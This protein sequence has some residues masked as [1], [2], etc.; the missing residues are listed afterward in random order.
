MRHLGLRA[1]PKDIA[2]QDQ[3]GG[4]GGGGTVITAGTATINF[5]ASPGANEASIAV[6]GQTLILATSKV[7][8]WIMGDDTSASH[9]ANDHRYLP[10]IAAF[11]AGTPTAG[12]GFTIYGRSNTY[13]T[14]T[15]TLRWAWF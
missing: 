5:G 14:G 1:D 4:G 13:L 7:K 2:S 6:T 11:T 3:L 8:V 15:Y 10:L 9:T 12:T